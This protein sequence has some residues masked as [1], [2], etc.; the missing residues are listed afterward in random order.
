[1]TVKDL[2]SLLYDVPDDTEVMVLNENAPIKGTVPVEQTFTIKGDKGKNL[3]IM[4]QSKNGKE[5][6]K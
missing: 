3:V 2:R 1:M 6:T 5:G 4:Y